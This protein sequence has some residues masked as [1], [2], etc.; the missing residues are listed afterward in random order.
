M[1]QLKLIPHEDVEKLGHAGDV[2]SVK[3]GYG[4]NYLLPK[5]KA[6]LATASRVRELEHTQRVISE[7]QA[8]QLKDL[9]GLKT[10]IESLTLEVTAQAGA[11]GKL[12]GSVTTQQVAERLADKGIDIDR[13]KLQTD[14]PIKTLGEHSVSLRLHRELVAKVKVVV[15]SDTVEQ[16]P[17]EKEDP[18]AEAQSD[19]DSE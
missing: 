4:R 8:K 10:K 1:A 9:E 16:T 15:S 14:E 6:S 5:G 19:D 3:P 17:A 13:R 18:P 2:V 7:E 11:E 12:F